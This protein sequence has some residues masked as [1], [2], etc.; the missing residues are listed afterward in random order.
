MAD[1]QL[2]FTEEFFEPFPKLSAESCCRFAQ[3][4]LAPLLFPGSE[5]KLNIQNCS[6]QGSMS[7]TIILSCTDDAKSMVVQFRSEEE[8]LYGVTEAHRIHGTLVPMVTYHGK[9][10]ELFV[11]SSPFAPGTSYLMVLMSTEDHSLPLPIKTATI[12]D[13]ADIVSR[14][15]NNDSINLHVDNTVLDNIQCI[16]NDYDFQLPHLRAKI[17]TC[18]NHL[19]SRLADLAVLPISLAHQDMSTWNYLIDEL[20]GHILTIL[21]WDG[22]KYQTLGSNF[23]FVEDILGCMT[24]DGWKDDEDRNALENAF[25]TRVLENLQNQGIQNVNKE[26]LELQ[27][28]IGMLPYYLG[29][30]SRNPVNS[31]R[32]EMYIDGQLRG[33]GFMN[34]LA[35][36]ARTGSA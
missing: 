26:L 36:P 1:D 10:E 32:T 17:A 30:L 7:H 27:K 20:S 6:S 12:C 22:A 9:Y 16:I 2:S 23:H 8:D 34:P 3:Q 35:I 11:Y 25:Y 15:V 29:R 31:K 14:D 18:I 21:D 28:A 13:L 19:R 24:P 5:L 4:E 33:L